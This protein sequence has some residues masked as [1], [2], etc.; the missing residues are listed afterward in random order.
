MQSFTTFLD[1]AF[2]V[3][4]GGDTSEGTDYLCILGEFLLPYFRAVP[5]VFNQPSTNGAWWA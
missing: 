4:K 5:H 1:T 2:Q 3:A